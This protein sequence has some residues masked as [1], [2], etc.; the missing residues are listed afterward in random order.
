MPAER[1]ELKVWRRLVLPI[2][3]ILTSSSS[4]ALFSYQA[5]EEFERP[6]SQPFGRLVLHAD[7]NY[8]GTTVSGGSFGHGTVFRMTPAGVVTTLVSF[9]GSAGTAPGSGPVGGVVEG[10]D[11]ALFGT[12]SA[13]GSSGLGLA[14]RVTTAGTY[15]TLVSFSGIVGPAL[16]SVP[17]PL[18]LHA[19]G[20][21]YGT[22]QAGG[23]GGAGGMGTVFQM[24]P[25]G[26]VTT[27]VE[28]TGTAGA[29][30]GAGPVGT[31]AVDGSTLFGV[32]GTGG[33]LNNGTIFR[34]TTAGAWT[35]MA[36][37]TGT[38]GIP[39]EDFRPGAEPAAGLLFHS[40]GN[41]YGTT[42]FG[43]TSGFGVAFKIT[44]AATPVFTVLHNFSDSTGSQPVGELLEGSDGAMYGAAAAGGLDGWGAVYRLTV[45][46][47]H[48]VLAEF[49]G[50]G[51]LVRGAT[52]RAG[53]IVGADG[54]LHGTTS[55]G[56]AGNLGVAFKITIA[57]AYTGLANLSRPIG[58]VPAGA[59][60]EDGSG[61][62][63]VP[64]ATGGDH[65]N[66]VILRWN[67]AGGISVEDPLGVADGDG[68]AGGLVALGG[69]FYGVTTTGGG[70]GRGTAYKFVPGSGVSLVSDFSTFSGSLSEGPLLTAAGAF[71]GLSR[72]GGSSGLGTIYR[73]T[74]SGIRTRLVSFTGA[75]GVAPG[76]TPRGPL[77]LA[78]NA[79][80]YGVTEAGGADGAGVIFRLSAVGTYSLVVEFGTS[81]PRIPRGGLVL[82]LDGLLYGTT[83]A[84]GAADAGTLIQIDPATNLWSVVGEFTGTGGAAPGAAPAGELTVASD[85]T[86][87]GMAAGGG[88]SGF[89][90]VFRYMTGSGLETLVSLT[91]AA[92]A[93]PGVVAADLGS[94]VE[95]TGGVAAGAD[96]TLCV[97][98]AGGG[99]GGGGV[100]FTLTVPSPIV[101]WKQ[102]MLG[103]PN[104]PD[105]GDPDFDGVINLVEYALGM[106]PA[107]A[108]ATSQP[109]PM[110]LSY[111]EGERLA[112][113]LHRDPA[114]DDITVTV[115]VSSTLLD[116]WTVIAES[117]AGQPFTGPGVVGGDSATPGIKTVEIRDLFQVG[118]SSK[119]FL[120]IRVT[121]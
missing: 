35:L 102:T 22:T 15:S 88:A 116:P 30:P 74:T 69:D 57:G 39:P 38:T 5:V 67:P 119:R 46:G 25:A 82:G 76:A 63:L 108:D 8:Y 43:G 41:L 45:G 26:G 97:V 64:M 106:N 42:E 110:I 111:P 12:T 40:D 11:G 13:G 47:A 44:T 95:W 84:G 114:H 31:L 9:S 48:S 105:D 81:G 29:R 66:G 107:V 72:E 99:S 90:S 2:L 62:H 27:L 58:W 19:D 96:G 4:L 94:G 16:G 113:F 7:G 60:V 83:S 1:A 118:S 65:G 86:I 109:Q 34:V 117:V 79:S 70:F 50:E 85:G 101:D 6:G 33:A 49:T 87:Y 17:G 54:Q 100:A 78:P 93:A 75:A 21:F 20:N 89:G 68:P 103:D 92:G 98:A 23:A 121:R 77:V 55:A 3:F 14:F 112:I 71:F 115:E 10:A 53:L 80:F 73:L 24:T 91:G 52:P 37:F 36:E 104:A 56:G 61:D 120:R 51:G 32:T 18:V 59:P 28:F